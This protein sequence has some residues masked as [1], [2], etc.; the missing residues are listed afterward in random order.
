MLWILTKYTKK[1]KNPIAKFTVSLFFL[2]IV[3]GVTLTFLQTFSSSLGKYSIDKIASTANSTRRWISHMSEVDAGSAYDLG[4]FSPNIGGMLSKFPQAVNVSLF[5]PYI[6]EARKPIVFLSALE[7]LLFLFLTIKLILTLG[8]KKVLNTIRTEPSIQFCFIFSLIFAFAVGIT[9]YNFGALS[10]YKIP[11]LP[12]Y[13]MA[14]I[15][16]W[17]KH[18]PPKNRLFGLLNI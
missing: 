18:N 9:S 8:L 16:T 15:M 14:I 7:A 13:A 10:R 17:Y 5:R 11:G 3:S 6:W 2:V 1:I 12:F 4:A